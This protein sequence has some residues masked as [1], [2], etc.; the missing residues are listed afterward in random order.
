MY[1]IVNSVVIYHYHHYHYTHYHYHIASI[2]VHAAVA[3]NIGLIVGNIEEE[4]K[5]YELTSFFAIGK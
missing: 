4:D 2:G 1:S 3:L 5:T